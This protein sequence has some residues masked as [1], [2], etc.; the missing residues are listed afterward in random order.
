LSDLLVLKNNYPRVFEERSRDLRMYIMYFLISEMHPL[1]DWSKIIEEVD[2]KTVNSVSD[3]FEAYS[4]PEN[5]LLTEK[6]I[7]NRIA[8]LFR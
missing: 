3:S 1:N 4:H 6:D 2:N 7:R 5:T 8:S